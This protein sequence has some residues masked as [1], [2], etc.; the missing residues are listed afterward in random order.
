MVAD[1]PRAGP[2][3]RWGAGRRMTEPFE[4]RICLRDWAAMD[5]V[6]C[7]LMCCGVERERGERWIPSLAGASK[8]RGLELAIMFAF[9][10]GRQPEGAPPDTAQSETHWSP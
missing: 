6:L 4:R 3:L 8:T 5:F 7:F 2:P 10:S 1:F 9:H